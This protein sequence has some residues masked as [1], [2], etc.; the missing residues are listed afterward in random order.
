M[1]AQMGSRCISSTLSLTLALGGAVNATPSSLYPQERDP[2]SIAQKAGWA[3]GLVWMGEENVA[4]TWI[5]SLDRPAHR[6]V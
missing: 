1:K 3:A 5:R 4:T 6:Q 2:V